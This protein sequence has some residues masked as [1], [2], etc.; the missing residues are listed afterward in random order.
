MNEAKKT[1]EIRGQFFI[2]KYLSGKVIDIGAGNDLVCIGAERFDR[3]DGDANEI[4]KFRELN[5]YDAVHSSHCLEHMHEPDKALLEWWKIIKPD[6]YLVLVVPDEDLFE[7]GFW[8]S[9]FNDD[10]KATFTLKKGKSWSPVSYNILDLT[11][12]LPNSEIISVEIHDKNYDYKLQSKYP[13]PLPFKKLPL[14]FRIIRKLSFSLKIGNSLLES[15]QNR[16]FL[17]HQLPIDQTMRNALAQ[18]QVVARKN[19]TLL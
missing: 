3:E 17:S 2:N 9:L 4:T 18:I 12:S 8:P 1:N 14:W 7:Q 16:L 10:H 19:T 11:S 6:G 15:L 5:T 13:P